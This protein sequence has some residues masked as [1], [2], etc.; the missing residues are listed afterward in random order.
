[1]PNPITQIVLTAVDK[2]RAAFASVKGGLEELKNKSVDIFAGLGVGLSLAGFVGSI[3]N[4]AEKMDEAAKSARSAGTSIEKFSAL[5]YAASQAGVD[6]L[7]GSLVKLARSLD[8]A[9]NGTGPAAEAFQRLKIDPAA[10]TDPAD[11]L[12]ALADQFAKMADGVNKTAIAVA[13]FGK[14]GAELIPLLNGGREAIVA[15]MNEARAMGIVFSDEAGAAAEKFNDSL[16]RLSKR[17]SGLG[18]RLANDALP[19]LN[20]YVSALD[21]VISRGSTLDKIKFFTAGYISEDVMNRITDAGERVKDYDKKIQELTQHLKE[22]QAIGIAGPLEVKELQDLIAEYTNTRNSIAEADRKANEARKKSAEDA[23]GDIGK[24]YKAE[25]EDFKK[26]TNEKI[27]DAKRL[28]GALQSAFQQALSEEDQYTKEAK[29]LRDKASQP[30]GNQNQDSIRYDATTAALKLQR[31]KENGTPDEIR[32][33]A[34]AVRELA[35][36]LQDKAYA[37]DLAKQADAAQ[38]TAADKQAKEA[39]DRAAGLAEQLNANES[40][41]AGYKSALDGLEKPV[42]LDIVPTKATD[43]SI[44]KLREAKALIEYINSTPANMQVNMQDMEGAVSKVL[45]TA[46]LKFGRR[47]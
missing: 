14:S 15:T 26:A 21:D 44:A 38:A 43:D 17:V 46:A 22:R 24:S 40:R 23:A 9:K 28:Q 45:S 39:K 5:S 19:S 47:Q 11:A 4:A 8:D 31:L 18:V 7:R 10:F 13:L 2:T 1:M 3:K 29:R 32:Q 36:S 27:S 6:D 12:L 34:D 25:A 30:A 20:Q 35:A 16:D 41:M 33:Q 37:T 42:S